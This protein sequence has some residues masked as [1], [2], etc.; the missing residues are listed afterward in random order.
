MQT[1]RKG[2]WPR[3]ALV[4]LLLLT[5]LGVFVAVGLCPQKGSLPNRDSMSDARWHHFALAAKE[6]KKKS[7]QDS[8]AGALC[9]KHFKSSRSYALRDARYLVTNQLHIV[10]AGGRSQNWCA[11][12]QFPLSR[13]SSLPLPHVFVSP[14]GSGVEKKKE[15]KRKGSS[16]EQG[17][18]KGKQHR[19]DPR[20]LFV[21][22]APSAGSPGYLPQSVTVIRPPARTKKNHD[23]VA[24][25]LLREGDGFFFGL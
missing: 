3:A 19:R 5:P 8:C 24:A 12:W 16:S 21:S 23:I 22:S 11:A 9:V 25:L 14:L 2:I 7:Q 1:S 18:E 17:A 13:S 10:Y 20:P 15:Q 6:G 4:F